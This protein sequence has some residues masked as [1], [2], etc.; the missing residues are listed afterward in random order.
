MNATTTT[1]VNP[2]LKSLWNIPHVLRFP[3]PLPPLPEIIA[4][5]QQRITQLQ[6]IRDGLDPRAE[7]FTDLRVTT[8]SDI[9]ILENK[10]DEIRRAFPIPPAPEPP[11]APV[12]PPV[13][14]NSSA[15]PASGALGSTLPS[16]SSIPLRADSVTSAVNQNNFSASKPGQN[17]QPASNQPTPARTNGGQNPDKPGQPRT[18][19][20]QP[21]TNAGQPWTNPGQNSKPATHLESPGSVPASSSHHAPITTQSPSKSCSPQPTPTPKLNS[22][23]PPQPTAPEPAQSENITAALARLDP[24]DEDLRD[25]ALELQSR[26][27]GRS[28]IDALTPE[29]QAHIV[30]LLDVHPLRAVAKLLAEPPPLGMSFKIGKSALGAFRLA[31]AKRET[32]RRRHASVNDTI[33]L[34]NQSPDPNAAFTKMLERLLHIKTLSAASV[35][36]TSLETLDALTTTFIKF[37]KLAL[38]E[39]KQL[40]IELTK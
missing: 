12:V 10:L 23:I 40:H 24:D 26:L 4:M 6:R 3:D 18:E 15:V 2:T 39:R 11:K 21:R 17:P 9:T 1:H 13:P 25:A 31:Y 36:E 38:A 14:H 27:K 19:S 22:H 8:E 34:L 29:Q 5:I 30:A 35:P 37:R 7:N 32:E 33:T 28:R 20:G 16:P